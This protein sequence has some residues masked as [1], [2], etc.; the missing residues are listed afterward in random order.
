M[1]VIYQKKDKY[2]SSG[3]F[4]VYNIKSY[5]DARK[6]KHISYGVMVIPFQFSKFKQ[7]LLRK[8]GL[9]VQCGA[10]YSGYKDMRRELKGTYRFCIKDIERE[11]QMEGDIVE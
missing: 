2:H 4:W 5:K 6:G 10:G 7:W 8:L 11:E 9:L 3:D 1:R